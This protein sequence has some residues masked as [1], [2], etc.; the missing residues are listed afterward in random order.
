MGCCP[1]YELFNKSNLIFKFTQLNYCSL[2]DL[3]AVAGPKKISHSFGDSEKHRQETHPFW[4]CC[5]LSL[6]LR[7]WVSSL[8][9]LSSAFFA[10]SSPSNWLSSAELSRSEGAG[11]G[12]HPGPESPAL[13]QSAVPQVFGIR[14]PS[15]SPH[16]GV[17][18]VSPHWELLV[19]RMAF[20]WPGCSNV[21]WLLLVC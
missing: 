19:M 21:S 12:S 9:L 11:R 7:P 15:S 2:T 3:V 10:L 18:W 13:V 8:S 4:V 6:F 16:T 14:F 5:L 20:S 17:Y 1:I